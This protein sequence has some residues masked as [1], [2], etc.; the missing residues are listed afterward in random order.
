MTPAAICLTLCER[1][2][3]RATS[4]TQPQSPE[5]TVIMTVTKINGRCWFTAVNLDSCAAV[6]TRTLE[7]GLGLQV[8]PSALPCALRG[9]AGG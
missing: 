7:E 6:T 9:P 1:P 4:L 5:I 3:A 2:Q 8:A